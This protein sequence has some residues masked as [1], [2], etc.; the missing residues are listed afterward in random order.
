VKIANQRFTSI[1]NDFCLVFEKQGE[2]TE[3]AEDTN[4]LSVGYSFLGLNE[5][6]DMD[7]PRAIDIIGVV[8]R[9]DDVASCMLRSGVAKDKRMVTICDESNLTIQACFWGETT[10]LFDNCT[11][12]PVIAIKNVRVVE[13]LG[14]S[15]N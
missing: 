14:R 11:D 9:V 13:F 4:I 6:K 12:H 1:K 10:H 2:I 3:V 15:L 8:L 7:K 5:V